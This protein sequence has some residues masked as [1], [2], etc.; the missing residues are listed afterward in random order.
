MK[1]E[2]DDHDEIKEIARLLSNFV[3]ERVK[4]KL[5][6]DMIWKEC[7]EGVLEDLE[8]EIGLTEENIEEC[9]EE[10]LTINKIEREGYLRGLKTVV[11]MFTHNR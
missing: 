11:K 3:H 2:K 10:N 5:S 7:Y 4:E 8:Y 6:N 9:T 1:M